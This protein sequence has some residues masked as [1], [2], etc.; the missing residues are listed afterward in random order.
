M[1]Y[2][3]KK[4]SQFPNLRSYLSRKIIESR[5]ISSSSK[6]RHRRVYEAIE[7]KSHL[8]LDKDKI[9][10]LRD[11]QKCILEN[12]LP[13]GN[14]VG[15]LQ[16]KCCLELKESMSFS[17]WGNGYRI[18]PFKVSHFSK[19]KISFFSELI[20]KNGIPEKFSRR[21]D[22]INLAV[23]L[24]N[25]AKEEMESD[26]TLIE[27]KTSFSPSSEIT[28][29]IK[30]ETDSL[31]V[32]L[33]EEY[34]ELLEDDENNIILYIARSL[35]KKQDCKEELVTSSDFVF[36]ICCEASPLHQGIFDNEST[37]HT[38]LASSP[39]VFSTDLKIK[40]EG[41]ELGK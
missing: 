27:I 4:P 11:I 2:C 24:L 38:S 28:V 26:E 40:L 32:L 22:K 18:T 41:I 25:E 5:S 23:Q 37:K 31:L 17:I 19:D 39:E 15:S 36:N 29:E 9:Y 35:L 13:A 6:E 7:N 14:E 30:E 8:F 33:N 1:S 3:L 21:M 20:H 16:V 34:S 12:E 10:S